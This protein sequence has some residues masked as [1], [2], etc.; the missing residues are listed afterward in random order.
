MK[1]SMV[2]RKLL[3]DKINWWIFVDGACQGYEHSFG[4]W[5]SL[6]F[7]SNHFITSKMNVFLGTTNCVELLS[8]KT[9][10]KL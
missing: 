2:I 9:L 7:S 1:D 6:F 10:L 8:L 4:V 5:G 3:F